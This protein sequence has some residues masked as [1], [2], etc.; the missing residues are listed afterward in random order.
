ML[1]SNLEY[2]ISGYLIISIRVIMGYMSI[3]KLLAISGCIALLTSC[4]YKHEDKFFISECDPNVLTCID[5][6]EIITSYR[7]DVKANKVLSIITM[8]KHDNYQSSVIWDKEYCQIFDEKNWDCKAE[9]PIGL[10]WE[11]KMV[12]G[13]LVLA[14]TLSLSNGKSKKLYIKKLGFL[15]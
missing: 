2:P 1:D 4:S 13:N 14:T 8:P 6:D 9:G 5:H 11:R 10:V 7:V 15:D 3:G 12:D